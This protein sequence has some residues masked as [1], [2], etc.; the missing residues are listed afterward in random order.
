MWNNKKR[1]RKK[2]TR[3]RQRQRKPRE[4]NAIQN[5][6]F[7][8]SGRVELKEKIGQKKK[9]YKRQKKNIFI[10]WAGSLSPFLWFVRRKEFCIP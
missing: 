6:G 3:K 4:I 9:T 10:F 5:A 2:N 1:E 7:I 8:L